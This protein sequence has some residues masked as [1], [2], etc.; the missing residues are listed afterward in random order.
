MKRILI[1]IIM[2]AAGAASAA[3]HG[4][5]ATSLGLECTATNSNYSTTIGFGS[6]Y[7]AQFDIRDAFLGCIAGRWTTSLMRCVGI[8]YGAL[9]GASN[10]TDCVAIGDKAGAGWRNRTGWV[11]VGGAFVYT[12]GVAVVKAQ[13]GARIG[14]L[15]I[16]SSGNLLDHSIQGNWSVYSD[17][18]GSYGNIWAD[19]EVAGTTGN[20]YDLNT[21]YISL[22][23]D[24]SRDDRVAIAVDEQGRIVVTRNGTLLGYLT[25]TPPDPEQ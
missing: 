20:F 19:G 25:I 18:Q 17:E 5:G 23:V 10:C 1:A 12:N 13:N 7:G 21:E 8:G 9:D 15:K 14:P 11:D 24:S 3:I 22:G 4:A 2:A 16:E 6:G